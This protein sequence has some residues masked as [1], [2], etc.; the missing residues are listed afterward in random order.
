M[1]KNAIGMVAR[2]NLASDIAIQKMAGGNESVMVGSRAKGEVV[3]CRM[4]AEG[5]ADPSNESRTGRQRSPAAIITALPPANPGRT[6]SAIGP[7]APAKSCVLEPAAIMK[8]R[9]AP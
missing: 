4:A 7:P 5:Q 6:P 3:P 1:V 9:P 8:R 2:Q